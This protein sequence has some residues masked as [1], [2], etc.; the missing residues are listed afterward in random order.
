MKNVAFA[1]GLLACLPGLAWAEDPLTITSDTPDYCL[2][3]AQRMAS[4]T[5]SMPPEVL[6]LWE[7]GRDLCQHGHVRGGLQRLRRALMI[8]RGAAE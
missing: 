2:S 4:E 1:I 6:G 7:Q 3:L 8:S 5:L